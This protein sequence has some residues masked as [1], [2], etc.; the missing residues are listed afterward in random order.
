[1]PWTREQIEKIPEVYRDFMMALKPV[2]DTRQS[3]M[4]IA[5]IP[6]GSVYNALLTRYDFGPQQV[7]QIADNLKRAGLIEEDRLSF[8][9]PTG[10]GE[11]LIEAIAGTEETITNGVP[12]FPDLP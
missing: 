8:L 2:I 3:V 5:A 6:L 4:T 11:A 10:K 7:R 9:T 12:P 1:M